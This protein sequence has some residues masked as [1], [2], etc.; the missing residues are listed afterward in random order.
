LGIYSAAAGGR[1]AGAA[2]K[3]FHAGIHIAIVFDCVLPQRLHEQRPREE[4]KCRPSR[5]YADVQLPYQCGIVCDGGIVQVQLH[6]WHRVYVVI[7]IAADI[8]DRHIYN[9]ESGELHIGA[10]VWLRRRV[11]IA[12]Q[13]P[14]VPDALPRRISAV[15]QC[16]QSVHKYTVGARLYLLDYGVWDGCSGDFENNSLI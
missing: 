6:L 8:A 2:C 10:T 4:C 13:K 3:V 5:L 11:R 1:A 12:L 15:R 16:W 14:F 7:H 9:K